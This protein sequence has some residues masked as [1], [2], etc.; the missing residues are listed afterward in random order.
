MTQNLKAEG[1]WK[2]KVLD[3]KFGA[4]EKRSGFVQINV[5]IAEGPNKG[6]KCTYEDEINA[7]SAKYAA[8][9]AQAV[10]FKGK[11]WSTLRA[12]IETWVKE[13]GGMSTVE[14][15]HVPITKGK[16][17]GTVWDKVNSIGRRDARELTE[18]TGE[19]LSDA[20]E[21]LRRALEDEQ[22]SGGGNY[23]DDVPPPS[24]DDDIPF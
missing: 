17:A 19:T 10:G 6:R 5:E 7:K 14:I 8:K 9:S 16:K 23:D 1:I 24:D 22:S 4:D 13:T 18:A 15:R 11:S 20:D 2:C 3:G 12:D 21:Q